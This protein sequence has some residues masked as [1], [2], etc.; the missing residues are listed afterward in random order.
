MFIQKLYNRLSPKM[1]NYGNFF[2][3]LTY[4]KFN[5]KDVVVKTRKPG[6]ATVFDVSHMGIFETNRVDLIEQHFLADLSKYY[7][8]SKLVSLINKKGHI[9]DDII[10]GD[11][12][13]SKYRL[14][15]N[16]ASKNYFRNILDFHEKNK[17]VIAIQ[18]D[19]SQK[20]LDNMFST[21]LDNL[22]FMENLTIKKD[23][24]EIC[25]CGYTGEDGFELYLN[26][27]EG[28]EIVEN[29]VDLSLKAITLFG[30]LIER[31]LT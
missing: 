23:A 10:I 8:R 14:V 16:A 18:G 9:V 4:R 15:V 17:I 28:E 13:K 27:C 21:N 26:K 20:I 7:N 2:L 6:F 30:G 25:R 31:D 24:I 5:T 19:H 3:P 22:Y 29:L 12:D 11:V 1:G